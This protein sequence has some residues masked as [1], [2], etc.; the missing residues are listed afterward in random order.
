MPP[1]HWQERQEGTHVAACV[2]ARGVRARVCA[3]GE[4]GH[5]RNIHTA[6]RTRAVWHKV[7]QALISSDLVWI[8]VPW[9]RATEGRSNPVR[10]QN[11]GW[12]VMMRHSRLPTT[13]I[14][15][16]GNVGTVLE[17][18][19][20]HALAAR[21]SSVTADGRENIRCLSTPRWG[22]GREQERVRGLPPPA[23][24]AQQPARALSTHAA[25]ARHPARKAQ[26]GTG[27]RTEE[28]GARCQ[29]GAYAAP[30]RGSMAGHDRRTRP[31]GVDPRTADGH[32]GPSRIPPH[33][34]NRDSSA[35]AAAPPCFGYKKKKTPVL[36]ERKFLFSGSWES[37]SSRQRKRW[38]GAARGAWGGGGGHGCAAHAA[39]A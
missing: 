9:Q 18:G 38:V 35:A 29:A 20:A 16:R 19:P 12:V 34:P 15:E 3:C 13:S 25:H 11:A 33:T 24:Q 28:G 2:Q 32:E 23:R 26:Q 6:P 31:P 4:T 21:I 1:A 14:S 39:R 5:A 30:L 36:H 17:R 22:L 37:Y 8:Q 10:A 27:V 7:L